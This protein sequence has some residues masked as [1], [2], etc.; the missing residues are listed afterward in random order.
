MASKWVAGTPM[1]TLLPSHFA[2]ALPVWWHGLAELQGPGKHALQ[3]QT[4]LPLYMCDRLNLNSGTMMGK[5]VFSGFVPVSPTPHTT[6]PWLLCGC[7]LSVLL[8][9][10]CAVHLQLYS[11]AVLPCCFTVLLRGCFAIVASQCCCAA[12]LC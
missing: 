12:L 4:I 9:S 5:K 8:C 1:Q 6:W 3:L 2:E 11:A 10:C 7:C